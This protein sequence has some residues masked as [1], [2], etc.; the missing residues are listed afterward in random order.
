MGHDRCADY[1]HHLFSLVYPAQ[2]GVHH[3]LTRKEPLAPSSSCT[4]D[5]IVC[6]ISR[7]RQRQKARG[8]SEEQQTKVETGGETSAV[9][10]TCIYVPHAD[11][12]LPSLISALAC[13]W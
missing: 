10:S 1:H 11:A 5:A 7:F 13:H 2:Q 6:V 3:H 4:D 12:I 8:T 9:H